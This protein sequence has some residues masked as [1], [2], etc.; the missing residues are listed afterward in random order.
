[1][2]IKDLPT[3]TCKLDSV[4][5]ICPPRPSNLNEYEGCANP[6]VRFE[7]EWRTCPPWPSN[8]KEYW[9]AAHLH[10][11]FKFKR[12]LPICSPRLSTLK[13]DWVRICFRIAKSTK[14][15]PTH[16]RQR[17]REC[18]RNPCYCRECWM[19]SPLCLFEK[20]SMRGKIISAT[21]D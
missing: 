1:M 21:A 17:H 5:R 12:G 15:L 2:S 3:Q 8:S 18:M 13:E 7:R 19:V 11:T 10:Y 20:W 4:S 9:G 6:G 14:E 16:G